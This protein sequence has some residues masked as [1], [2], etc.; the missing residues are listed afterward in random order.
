[1]TLN[2]HRGE[3]PKGKL[4]RTESLK[5]TRRQQMRGKI[6][7]RLILAAEQETTYVG[8]NFQIAFHYVS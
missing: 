3:E 2:S 1:M 7:K 5:D 6:M 4:L 8:L